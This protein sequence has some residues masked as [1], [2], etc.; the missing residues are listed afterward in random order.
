MAGG[1]GRFDAVRDEDAPGGDADGENSRLGVFG[2]PEVFIR[3]FE[4]QFGERETEGFVGLGKGL[5][6]DGK[7]LGKVAAHADRLRT[8]ARKEKGDLCGHFRE[9]CNLSPR[10]K[11]TPC[12][13]GWSV[14][15][16]SV[17]ALLVVVVFVDLL[18]AAVE[19]DGA[20]LG[21][22]VDLELAGGAAA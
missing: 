20:A 9:D 13:G 22:H 5:G 17:P 12:E 1:E 10:T 19:A 15:R 2:E 21:A 8:L 11:S 7:V 4:D 14:R 6:G 3:A 16:M 18:A